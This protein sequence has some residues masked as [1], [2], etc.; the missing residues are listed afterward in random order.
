M[1]KL[2]CITLLLTAVGCSNII[3]DGLQYDR[4]VYLVEDANTLKSMCGKPDIK[5]YI[6]IFKKRTDHMNAYATYRANSPEVFAVTSKLANM[7]SDLAARYED[8]TPSAAYCVEK[9]DNI[10]AGAKTVASTLGAQ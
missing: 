8:G 3:F 10:A 6:T 1:K 5:E 7:V 4:Y 2:I 9:L